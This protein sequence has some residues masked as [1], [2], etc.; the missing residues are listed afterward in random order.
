VPHAYDQFDNAMRLEQL[1]V[2]CTLA[3][4]SGARQLIRALGR[5]LA[6]ASVA[7]CAAQ[8]AARMR[9]D[10]GT[11]AIVAAVERCA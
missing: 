7:T 6:D 10:S 11:D 1:G 2:G 3:P 5:H 4:G 9:A 8:A